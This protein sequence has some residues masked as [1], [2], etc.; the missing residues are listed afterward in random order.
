M[1][2]NSSST[3]KS[4]SERKRCFIYFAF[5]MKFAS[6]YAL[7]SLAGASAFAPRTSVVAPITRKS[8]A[9]HIFVAAPVQDRQISKEDGVS[10]AF[11]LDETSRILGQPIPYEELTIGVMKETFPGENRVSQTP[12]SVMSLIKAGFQV[13]VQEG[14]TFLSFDSNHIKSYQIH[15]ISFHCTSNDQD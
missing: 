5:V 8:K 4:S 9:S 10:K 13:V 1:L 7:A 14:G 3:S 15:S 11:N 12:E 6:V 2:T